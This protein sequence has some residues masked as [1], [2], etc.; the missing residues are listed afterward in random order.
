M[1]KNKTTDF[2]SIKQTLSKVNKCIYKTTLAFDSIS[3]L[4]KSAITGRPYDI[5]E[6]RPRK[7][8]KKPI[9][10]LHL[11]LKSQHKNTEGI[12]I[13]QLPKLP[14][15]VHHSYNEETD[16]IPK[17]F[18]KNPGFKE[19]SK[20]LEVLKRKFRLHDKNESKKRAKTS[21]GMRKNKKTE[22]D[23][24]KMEAGVLV[25]PVAKELIEIYDNDKVLYEKLMKENKKKKEPAKEEVKKKAQDEIVQ[26][27]FPVNERPESRNS[28]FYKSKYSV[29]FTD[30]EG[31]TR[32]V[33]GMHNKRRI[34]LFEV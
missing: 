19:I 15:G 29:L 11:Y 21:H 6:P 16:F 24:L 4:E 25:C 27:L 1:Q 14:F 20:N 32:P 2:E 5:I 8:K 9:D 7:K 10:S 26:R 23:Y 34:E 3:L 31:S 28:K 22:F 18:D 12:Q 33:T 13:Y 30:T 17:H